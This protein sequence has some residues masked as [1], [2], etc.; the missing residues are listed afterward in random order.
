MRKVSFSNRV[1]LYF[2]T[3]SAILTAV[4]FITIYSVV[5][6]TVYSHIA[7]DLNAESLELFNSIVILSDQII[8]ANPDEWV[9]REHGQIEVNPTF[10]QFADTNG[11]VVKKS[12]N[13]LDE[14]LRIKHDSLEKMFF[15]DSISGSRIYQLQLPIKNHNGKLLGFL[16]VAFPLDDTIMVL[17]NLRMVLLIAFPIVLFLIYF[18]SDLIAH[19][20]IYPVF[21]L[22]NTAQRITSTNLN[23]RIELP[24]KKDELYTLTKTINNLIDRLQGAVIREKQFTSDAS[25]ELRTPLSILRG[26]FEVTLR[27]PRTAD[28]YEEKIKTGLIEINRMSEL[29]EQLLLLAR[30]ESGKENIKKEKIFLRDLINE[31]TSRLY[32]DA[33]TKSLSF[34]LF[35]PNK[36]SVETDRFMLGQI[37]E[38]IITNAIKYSLDNGAIQIEAATDEK[39]DITISIK[40][41]GIGIANEELT[42]IFERFYRID[43]SR[44]P[45]TKGNGLGL[46]IVKRFSDILVISLKAESVQGKGSTFTLTI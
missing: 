31:I 36:L 28:Y 10:I 42:N 43:E 5:Y 24:K 44:S 20:S 41:D 6:K 1:A 2:M 11:I 23:E 39:D 33:K 19:K 9:E 4:I 29:V 7:D 46:S 38:N 21:R 45:A 17:R 32:P 16:S 8:F 22:T 27:R 34:D 15:T 18:I 30:F 3:A 12:A 37:I 25:H 40:D 26:N 14:N 13:L 35:I